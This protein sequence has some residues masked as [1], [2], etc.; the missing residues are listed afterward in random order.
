MTKNQ[1]IA[2]LSIAIVLAVLFAVDK[3][4]G[5]LPDQLSPFRQKVDSQAVS[6]E[7]WGVWQRYLTAAKEHDLETI[8]ALSHQLSDACM[9]QARRTE[10]DTLMDNVY[11]IGSELERSAFTEVLADEKQVILTGDY[12]TLGTEESPGAGMLRPIM[13]FTRPGGELKVLALNPEDGAIVVDTELSFA[14]KQEKLL[15]ATLDTDDDSLPDEVERCAGQVSENCTQ[16]DPAKRDTDSDGWWDSI[17]R[18]FR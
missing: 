9:D 17:E 10:C 6:D 11:A 1:T 13:Y 3:L 2:I 18:L 15:E 12:E 14:E 16:T 4:A 8:T 7:A 5:I